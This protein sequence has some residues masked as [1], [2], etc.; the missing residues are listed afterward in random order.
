MKISEQEE[1]TLTADE[2]K[3]WLLIETS[4]CKRHSVVLQHY[5]SFETHLKA[6]RAAWCPICG[7]DQMVKLFLKALLPVERIEVNFTINQNG[8]VLEEQVLD[9]SALRASAGRAG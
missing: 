3:D 5:D 8:A 1:V 2:A 9:S 7:S 6:V 4:V